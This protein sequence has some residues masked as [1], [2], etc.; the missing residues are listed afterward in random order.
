M[1]D[2]LDYA[3]I[4]RRVELELQQDRRRSQ[5]SL[6]VVNCLLFVLFMVI[7]WG[8]F[9]DP[10]R[11]SYDMEGVTMLL[12]LGWA[13]ALLLNGI[14]VLSIGSKR[15]LDR[16]RQ[17]LTAREIKYAKMGG[18]DDLLETDYVKAKRTPDSRL[19]LADE[20]ELIRVTEEPDRS[21]RA[22]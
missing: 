13:I 2:D 12:S 22:K 3:A 9:P 14:A 1:R 11:P 16:H 15:W 10:L 18:E 5:V 20:D 17:S 6:F 21:Q 7:A 19:R 4:R 8:V